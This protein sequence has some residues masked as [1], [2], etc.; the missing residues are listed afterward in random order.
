GFRPLRLH[1]FSAQ[2]AGTFAV[3]RRPARVVSP[4]AGRRSTSPPEGLA[5]RRRW[6]LARHLSCAFPSAA[7]VASVCAPE[8]P[9]PSEVAS[10]F[11]A[12]IPFRGSWFVVVPPDK[13]D[14]TQVAITR[15]AR[16]KLSTV[17][18]TRDCS[19]RI[20]C[21]PLVHKATKV[22]P[23]AIHSLWNP[24]AATS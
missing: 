10:S 12:A 1:A 18:G 2:R 23:T 8:S 11:E 6:T 14:T 3:R 20:G 5:C 4:R 22:F 24:R 21:L 7:E 15:Q 9:S 16:H 17:A 13:D 19:C